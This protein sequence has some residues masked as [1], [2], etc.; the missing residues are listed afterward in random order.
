VTYV[1]KYLREAFPNLISY[2]HFVNHVKSILV[3]LCIFAQS[4]KGEK[5]GIYFV[6][7]LL[8]KVCHIK[9]EKQNRVFKGLAKKS[10]S[11]LQN[12]LVLTG[13][14]VLAQTL[15]DSKQFCSSDYPIKSKLLS[16]SKV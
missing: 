8:L 11:T 3:P 6:D 14:S 12:R 5:T 7:S 1:Q 16:S 2:S 4:L 9:R 15:P 13:C 10:K